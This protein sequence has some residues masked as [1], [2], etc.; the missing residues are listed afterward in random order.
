MVHLIKLFS[1]SKTQFMNF[2]VR[3][4]FPTTVKGL[5]G[6]PF[7]QM[8][9]SFIRFTSLLKISTCTFIEFAIQQNTQK[10]ACQKIRQTLLL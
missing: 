9:L 7:Q 6:P 1:T 10:N 4:L 5:L 3:V 2:L 8:A